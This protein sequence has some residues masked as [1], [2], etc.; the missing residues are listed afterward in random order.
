MEPKR[1]AAEMEGMDEGRLRLLHRLNRIQGQLEAVKRS[2]SEPQ[3]DC[4]R[5]MQLVKASI[6]ATKK[7]A[8]AY[9]EQHLSECLRRGDSPRALEQDLRRVITSAFSL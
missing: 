1:R 8:E 9:V 4:V 2:L 3:S 5:S 7:F 6:Q